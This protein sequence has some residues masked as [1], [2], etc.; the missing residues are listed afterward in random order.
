[1]IRQK[2]I[3]FGLKWIKKEKNIRREEGGD[4]NEVA[5]AD[6]EEIESWLHRLVGALLPRS[7]DE[8]FNFFFY[9]KCKARTVGL[10]L[11][12]K[13]IIDKNNFKKT[14]V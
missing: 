13:R 1:M 6:E 10:H 9:P 14:N 11:L 12:S 8:A 3:K 5:D 7:S 4:E 2:R